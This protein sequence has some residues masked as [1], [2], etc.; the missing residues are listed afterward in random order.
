MRKEIIAQLD[1]HA[2]FG[3]YQALKSCLILQDEFTTTSGPVVDDWFKGIIQSLFYR[4]NK[5]VL[6][7]EYQD[8]L[9]WFFR[10]LLPVKTWYCEHYIYAEHNSTGCYD[11]LINNC[12]FERNVLNVPIRDDGIVVKI[13]DEW[14]FEKRLWSYCTTTDN[15]RYTRSNFILLRLEEINRELYNSIDKQKLW[16]EIF[17]R[18]K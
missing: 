7:L 3:H 6:V 16:I 8:D 17:N 9:K 15:W 10:D 1:K 18:F 14:E 5:Y 11:H 4:P 13:N 12:V 2:E